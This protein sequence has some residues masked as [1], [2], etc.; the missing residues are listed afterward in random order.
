MLT[1]IWYQFLKYYVKIAFSFYYKKIKII[2]KENIPK[3]GAILFVCNHPNALIDPLLIKTNTYKDLSVLTRAGVFV[4]KYIIKIFES[5]KMI[6]IY[7]KRDGFSTISKNEAIFEKCYD[8]LNDKKAILI[9]PEGSHSLLRKVRPLSKGFTRITFGAFEKYPDLDIQIVPIGLNYK[10]PSKFP[11]SVAIHFGKP[12]NARD[13][14]NANDLFSSMDSLKKETQNQMEKLAIHIEGD[15]EIYE[16]ALTKLKTL[17][18]DFTDPI[19]TNSL[20]KKLNQSEAVP[21]NTT[22][23]N[24]KNFLYYLV[25]INSFIP[26]IIWNKL[27]KG[28]KEGEFI[29]TFRFA[30]SASL[31]PFVY[32]VQS[33]IIYAFF[34]KTVALIYFFLSVISSFILSK[35][36]KVND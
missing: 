10:Q 4:N 1:K 22:R 23:K 32:I 31:F 30:I 24:R 6:P 8:I 36:L 17:N 33:F 25:M 29:S 19:K 26:W 34:N 11:D 28:I 18:A 20:I 14:Y 5:V 7:R 35:T 12:I 2:G 21:N 3:K 16:N 27:K 15:D 13:F 9:F